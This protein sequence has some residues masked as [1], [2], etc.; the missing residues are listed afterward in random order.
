MIGRALRGALWALLLSAALATAG[1]AKTLPL[2][3]GLV[4]LNSADGE[5]ALLRSRSKTAYW[6]LSLQF[7]TQKTQS[8]CGVASMVM[9]LNAAGVPAPTTPEYEP[10]RIFTQDNI[11]N[12]A[13]EAI[14]PQAVI[15]RQGITLDQLGSLVQSFGL[16]AAVHHAADSNLD[17]FRAAAREH[18]ATPGQFVLVNYL[19]KALGQ[20]RGGHISPLAA[21]DAE[22]DSFLILDVAR[23]KYPPV[24]VKAATLFDAMNTPDSDNRNLSRGFVLIGGGH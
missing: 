5:Q 20:E 19:R 8:F 12:A 11:F 6:D 4:A 16:A 24:W 1:W 17:S 7:V 22:S 10:Y 18:L 3:E 9:V 2:A 21:Y 23:Y 15:L 13:T 14:L